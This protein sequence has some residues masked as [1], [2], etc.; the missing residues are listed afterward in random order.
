MQPNANQVLLVV[1]GIKIKQ[2]AVDSTSKTALQ[3]DERD[4]GLPVS[5]V[6]EGEKQVLNISPGQ[7]GRSRF[8]CG[9]RE[10]AVVVKNL[11]K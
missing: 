5:S 4:T 6:L 10:P 1:I 7:M 9:K 11:F 2:A 8:I 3:T